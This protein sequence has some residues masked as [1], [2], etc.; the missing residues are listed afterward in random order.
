M[1]LVKES[2]LREVLGSVAGIKIPFIPYCLVRGK[3]Q[4]AYEQEVAKRER[5][6]LE[7]EMLLMARMTALM[8]PYYRTLRARRHLT[9]TYGSSILLS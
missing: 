6:N 1:R 2:K 9:R 8:Q 5:A 3:T 4:E 7:S